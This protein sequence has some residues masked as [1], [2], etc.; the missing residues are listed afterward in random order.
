MVT[1]EV[2]RGAELRAATAAL[3]EILSQ[4]VNAGASVSF[5]LPFTPPDGKA[6]FEKCADSADRSERLI[7]AASVDGVF[8]G[9]VQVLLAMPP[10]QPHRGEIAKLL[11]SPAFRRRGIARQLMI[12]AESAA[13]S[14]GKWLLLLDTCQGDSAEPL[15]R[16][17]GYNE[18]GVVPDYA[19]YPDGRLVGTV[20]FWK[21]LSVVSRA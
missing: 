10:N 13:I 6:F 9:T 17:L 20:F 8:A 19:L 14:A 4:C 3:G 2:L 11:V 21:K 12:E 7:L 18:V 1:I 15:Y 16:S 5:M